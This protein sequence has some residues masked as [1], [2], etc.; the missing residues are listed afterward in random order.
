MVVTRQISYKY[1]IGCKIHVLRCAIILLDLC[2]QSHSNTSSWEGA[3][4]VSIGN[5]MLSYLQGS[6]IGGG[7]NC[8]MGIGD[9]FL[10]WLHKQYT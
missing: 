5:Q 3:V 6:L 7:G 2:L 10:A 9:T 8:Q 4:L 1:I